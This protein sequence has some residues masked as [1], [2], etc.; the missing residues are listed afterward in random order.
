M[1]HLYIIIL[2]FVSISGFTQTNHHR[3]LFYEYE[4]KTY[5]EHFEKQRLIVPDHRYDVTF[6]H[7][8]LEIEIDSAYIQGNVL[9]NITLLQNTDDIILDLQDS[10]IVSSN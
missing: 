9:V 2:L 8:D 4:A 7:L 5:L 3:E 6:Y 1:K 10:L